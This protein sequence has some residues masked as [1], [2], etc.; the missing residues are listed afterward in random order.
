MNGN[1]KIDSAR[2][3]QNTAAG[4]F[5]SP[6]PG[7]KRAR[8]LDLL[9]RPAGLSIEQIQDKFGWNRKDVSDAFRLL[10][11]RNGHEVKPDG[12]GR[13]HAEELRRAARRNRR[14]A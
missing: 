3:S 11:T 10:R 1:V 14:A 9:S 13:Y 7:S 6:R 5:T 4:N 8:L 2:S 12:R